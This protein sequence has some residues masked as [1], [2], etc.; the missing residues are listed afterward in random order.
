ML[1]KEVVFFEDASPEEGKYRLSSIVVEGQVNLYS[2]AKGQ[3]N[4][5]SIERDA[6]GVYSYKSVN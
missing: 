3:V 5:V 6:E 2:Y 4:L 1:T